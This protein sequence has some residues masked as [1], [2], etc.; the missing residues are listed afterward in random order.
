M[1]E[2]VPQFGQ[3]W[4]Q[5]QMVERKLALPNSAANTAQAFMARCQMFGIHPIQ[6]IGTEAVAVG[7]LMTL[8]MPILMHGKTGP[9]LEVLIKTPDKMLSESLQRAVKDSPAFK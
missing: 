6:A 8:N 1:A 5:P 9:Q 2:Q 7:K 3:M 4:Q